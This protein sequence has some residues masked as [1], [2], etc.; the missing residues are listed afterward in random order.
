[1]NLKTSLIYLKISSNNWIYVKTAFHIYLQKNDIVYTCAKFEEDWLRIDD[2]FHL[3][4]LDLWPFDMPVHKRNVICKIH[5][6]VSICHWFKRQRLK[7]TYYYYEKKEEIWLS[8]ITKIPTPT[9]K[10]KTQ[11]DNNKKRHQNL[12]LHYH[13][14]PTWDCQLGQR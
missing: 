9:A 10:S 6:G 3:L 14:G 7:M 4:H 12:R 13:C 11:R 5:I 2:D 8:R 1:M